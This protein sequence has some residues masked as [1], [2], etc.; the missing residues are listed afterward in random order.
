MDIPEADKVCNCCGGA[1]HSF[2][3][4]TSEHLH[5]VPASLKIVETRRLKYSCNRCH[6]GVTRAQYPELPLFAKGMASASL[7][8]YLI[9]SKFADHL[10]LYRISKRL[11][12]LGIELSHRL[13]SQWLIEAAF[14]L[15]D[16]VTRMGNAV[17][18]TGHVFTDDTILPL[19]SRTGDSH[20]DPTRHRTIQARLWVYGSGLRNSEPLAYYA[21]SR[22]RSHEAPKHF[23]SDYEGFLQADAYPGYDVLFETGTITE[24]ACWA[25]A[26]R[27][28]VEVTT[29]MKEPGRAHHAIAFIKRLYAIE[30]AAR[31]LSDA[32]RL[33]IRQEKSMPILNQ[34]KIWLDE[35]MNAVLPKSALG[36]ALNYTLKNWAA[37]TCFTQHGQ[38]EADN[39]FAE[40]LMRPVTLGRKNFLFV[41]SE[42]G[43][44]A[45]A[46]YYSLMESCKLNK[47]N[48]LTYL[49]YLL[50]HVRNKQITLL[51]PQ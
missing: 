41:G 38:L 7:M 17:K 20:H 36:Q 18:A 37:L 32:E 8:A 29:V 48:P 1:L 28:F 40:R 44:Q 27:K 50:T 9:V 43:G 11:S 25:H 39:N 31:P 26:R 46:I 6:E 22:S 21:F 14:L 35:Q 5:Y 30:T 51:L 12:R 15:E 16:L 23:L 34:F 49:T 4:D 45:A 42:R 24:V 19:L 13:M 33:A 3:A 47:V 2:G 10:P